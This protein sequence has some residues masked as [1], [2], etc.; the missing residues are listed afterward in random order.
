MRLSG[1]TTITSDPEGMVESSGAYSTGTA[2]S[3]TGHTSADRG[4]PATLLARAAATPRRSQRRGQTEQSWGFAQ[5]K[6]ASTQKSQIGA[7]SPVGFSNSGRDGLRP[8]VS[9]RRSSPSKLCWSWNCDVLESVQILCNEFDPF[10]TLWPW[11][12]WETNHANLRSAQSKELRY[13]ECLHQ[14]WSDSRTS[15]HE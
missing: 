1:T 12:S 5:R 15:S 6:H 14:T 2:P 7:S 11:Q 3:T 10:A 9:R 13:C 4:L 8:L